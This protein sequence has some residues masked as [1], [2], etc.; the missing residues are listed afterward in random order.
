VHS[1][2]DSL[3][4]YLYGQF[5]IQC[6][7][8][9]PQKS[10]HGLLPCFRYNFIILNPLKKNTSNEIA[11]S[12]FYIF[13]LPYFPQVSPIRLWLDF[14]PVKIK[15]ALTHHQSGLCSWICKTCFLLPSETINVKNHAPTQ[16]RE[17]VSS[18][19][20]T[21]VKHSDLLSPQSWV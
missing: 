15:L 6:L 1:S 14:S 17:W 9:C 16:Q 4:S 18:T 3:I 11:S 8:V 12:L 19:L 2:V 5:F 20:E 10:C 21:S 13:L 7:W